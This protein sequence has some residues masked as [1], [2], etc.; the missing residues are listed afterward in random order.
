M[1][2]NIV[3]YGSNALEETEDPREQV[4]TRPSM[5]F[6]TNDVQGCLNGVMEIVTN[7]TDECTALKEMGSKTQGTYVKTIVEYDFDAIRA[8]DTDGAYVVTVIDNGRGVPM[9]INDK[10]KY[11]WDLV[12]N[13]LFA[14]G[15]RGT[16]SA[17]SGAAGLNGVGA[18][19][20]QFTSEFMRVISRRIEATPTGT[21]NVEYEMFFE[22]GR[23]KGTL[24]K[25]D[26]Q[27]ETAKFTGLTGTGTY[28]QYKTDRKYF[29]A[30]HYSFEML[31]DRLRKLATVAPGVKYDLKFLDEEPITF[32][33]EN[34]AV[35]FMKAII[36][37]PIIKEPFHVY[38]KYNIKDTFMGA[39]VD[40]DITV[41]CTI[42]FS[43]KQ[44]YIECYNNNI[45]VPENG[46]HLKGTKAAIKE[47]FEAFGVREKKFTAKEHILDSDL[48]DILCVIA[49]SAISK[50]EYC[51]WSGQDKRAIN[52]Q[53]LYNEFRYVVTEALK[54]CVTSHKDEANRVIDA[55]KLRREAR[56]KADQ[57]KK[58]L[59]KQITANATELKTRPEKLHD[60]SSRDTTKNE[61][62]IVEGDSAEGSA[63]TARNAIYQA[64]YPLTG[65]ILNV[66]K[67]SAEQIFKNRVIREL[68]QIAGCGIELNGMNKHYMKVLKDL[69]KFDIRKLHY[70]KI[71][72][73]TDA[74]IDGGHITC[75][76]LVFFIKFMPEIV[77]QGRLYVAEPPLYKIIYSDNTYVYAYN[78]TDKAAIL[79]ENKK[80]GKKVKYIKRFKGL[81]EMEDEEMSES[82][83]DV[84]TRRITQVTLNDEAGYA[85]LMQDL[86]GNNLDE[87]KAWIRTFFDEVSDVELEGE[88]AYLAEHPDEIDY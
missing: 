35:D 22:D 82:V 1:S 25:R 10:G 30:V 80:Y 63:L 32:Y 57:I 37:E 43:N 67:A 14:S 5:Y 60:C 16:N 88:L 61:L 65:V 8:G 2:E 81:G 53:S 71:I 83:M 36:E 52:N 34:G 7:G 38:K 26:W 76:L 59:V 18:A 20:T 46:T 86:L 15:K 41:D 49:A 66:E 13:K 73:L 55:I 3:S 58:K 75:L 51:A 78:D 33:F 27:E 31:A 17:Y 9:D 12:Y 72:I 50:G 28:V 47:V 4:Q 77:R 19:I 39:E 54:D 45:Y 64:T 6:G 85:A 70:G 11:G 74:D 69:P 21:K 44:G 23:P 84:N 62:F 79:E 68:I 24:I 48:D 42:A 56:E 40:Y 87:R 29:L